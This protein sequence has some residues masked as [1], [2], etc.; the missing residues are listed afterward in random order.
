[1]PILAS[2]ARRRAR[3]ADGPVLRPTNGRAPGYHVAM[4]R[5]L[6]AFSR[7]IVSQLHP[8]M[9]ALLVWPF[10]AAIVG[11]I[12]LAWFAWGPLV[13]WIAESLLGRFSVVQWTFDRMAA[14]GVESAPDVAATVFALLVAIPMIFATGLGLVAV[15][16]MPVVVRHLGER[17][18]EVQRLGSMSIAASAWNAVSSIAI[19]VVGYLLTMPLWLVPP[20]AFVV[21]WLWWSWLTARTMR[22]DSLAEHADPVERRAL[23]RTHRRSFLLLGMLVTLLNYIPPLFLITPVLS[24]LAYVHFSLD[25]LRRTRVVPA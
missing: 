20:L 22:F 11:W 17:Y 9:L 12:L 25:M 14:I 5:I 8:Q 7:S 19:F 23:I 2:P 3:V 18:P 24:A 1:M 13:D 21:P 6:A 4:H 10:L 15:L 16:A